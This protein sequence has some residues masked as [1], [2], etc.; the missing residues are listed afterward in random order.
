MVTTL[1][2]ES[3]SFQQ[4]ANSE[5]DRNQDC[6]CSPKHKAPSPAKVQVFKEEG[7]S[8]RI[9]R[10]TTCS[11]KRKSGNGGKSGKTSKIS[12]VVRSKGV[13][14]VARLDARWR[15]KGRENGEGKEK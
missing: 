15:R 7:C 8:R 9:N 2:I 13:V 3:L 4:D 10:S 6:S 5:S 12:K 1:L 14:R 11:R